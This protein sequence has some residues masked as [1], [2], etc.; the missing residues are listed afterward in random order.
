[1]LTRTRH[2]LG[3]RSVRLSFPILRTR[4][5]VE[6]QSDTSG[7]TARSGSSWTSPWS[8]AST[9]TGP[10]LALGLPGPD[11]SL[12]AVKMNL[13]TL[14]SRGEALR[15]SP[16]SHRPLQEEATLH[17]PPGS[18]LHSLLRQEGFL[19]AQQQPSQ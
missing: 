16:H 11:L 5:H 19:L 13:K 6:V 9:S 7:P 12:P 15:G 4:N 18:L 2:A 14:K 3:W 10:A 17:F 1:M 8:L